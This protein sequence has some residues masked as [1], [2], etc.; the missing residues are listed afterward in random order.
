MVQR[1][2]I[3]RGLEETLLTQLPIA[4]AVDQVSEESL[5]AEAVTAPA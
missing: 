4:E 5:T 1:L 3:A 2:S